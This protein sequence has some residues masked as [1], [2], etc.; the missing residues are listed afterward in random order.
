MSGSFARAVALL[1]GGTV[2]AQGLVFLA[3]PVLTRLYTPQHFESLA[4]FSSLVSFLGIAACLRFNVAIPLPSEDADAADL[5]LTSVVSAVFF[6]ILIGLAFYFFGTWLLTNLN[7]PLPAQYLW[8]LPLALLF[9]AIYDALQYWATRKKRFGLVTKTRI[10]RSIGG[11]FAQLGMGAVA[12]SAFG[13]ILGQVLYHG[14]GVIGIVKSILTLDRPLLSSIRLKRALRTAREHERYPRLSVPESL[15]NA[16]GT[17]LPVILIAAV[18]VG[19]EAGFLS[20]ALKALGAP[21]ALVGS[22]IGQVYFVEAPIKHR[23]GA[24]LQFT[25]SMMSR[26]LLWGGIPLAVVGATAPATFPLAFGSE[27]QRAGELAA[28]L[29]PCFVLQLIASPVSMVLHVTG[30][31][32]LSTKLQACGAII[33]IG[34]V[35]VAARYAPD[36]VGEVFAVTSAVY[37]GI[38]NA[39]ILKVLKAV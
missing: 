2:F 17:E 7:N 38:Y 20:L 27:W 26:L 4:V 31:L 9:A 33:R 18:T 3:M 19:P 6:S 32:S 35:T 12:P 21:M 36:Y 39:V 22:A 11:V 16:A 37:Y 28:W 8:L 10:T 14:L 13:L 30:H 23:E 1:A 15:L 24:L 29:T 25:N 34:A 5:L